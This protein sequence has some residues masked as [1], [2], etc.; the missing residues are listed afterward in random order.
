MG[1]NYRL[2]RS[3]R[4][5][6]ERVRVLFSCPLHWRNQIFSGCHNC[7][8]NWKKYKMLHYPYKNIELS[9]EIPTELETDEWIF[10]YKQTTFIEFVEYRIRDTVSKWQKK[11]NSIPLHCEKSVREIHF[12]KNDILENV[13]VINEERNSIL[14]N[15]RQYLYCYEC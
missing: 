11:Y 1:L 6:E 2:Q 9:Y 3:Y 14:L 12:Q 8:D 7:R 13:K 4:K 5:S 15:F 10:S